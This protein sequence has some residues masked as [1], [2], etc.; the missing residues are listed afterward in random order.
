MLLIFIAGTFGLLNI[1][2]RIWPAIEFDWVSINVAW[3]GASARE[4]ED[5]LIVKVEDR[6]AG[7]AGVVSVTA[8]AYDGSAYFGLETTSTI[9]MNTLRDEIERVFGDVDD[10]PEEARTPRIERETEWARVMLLF[11]YGEEDQDPSILEDVAEEFRQD[12]LKTGQVSEI[13]VWG[14]P[15]EEIVVEIDPAVQERLGI[16]FDQLAA[17]IHAANLD[18]SAGS[19]LTTR[20]QIQIRTYNK[21]TDPAEIATIPV[22]TG[23]DGRIITLG[24]IA[25]VRRARAENALYT[26]AN[27]RNAIGIQIMYNDLEDVVSLGKLADEKIAEYE[28]R[29]EGRIHFQPYIRDVDE[30]NE[31]LGTLSGSGAMG[32]VLVLLILGLLLNIRLS[33]WVAMGIPISFFGLLF[34]EWILGITINEMTLFGMIIVIGILVDDGIVIGENIYRHWKVL[35]KGRVEAA[36]DGTMEVIVPVCVS[37]ATT[38]VAFAPYFFIYGDMG[39]YVAQIG[40]VVIISLAFSLVE[41]LILLPAHLAHSKALTEREGDPPPMRAW[42]ERFQDRI[43]SGFYRP[44]LE[45][46]LNNRSIVIALLVTPIIVIAGAFIGNHIRAEFFPEVESQYVYVEATFP[47]GTPASEM[48]GVRRRLEEQSLAFGRAWARPERGYDNGIVDYLSWQDGDSLIIYLLLIPNT[49]RD[50]SVKDFG[51]ELNRAVTGFPELESLVIGEDGIFGGD[52]ISIRFLGRD[53]QQLRRA[54]D[55]FKERLHA[56]DGVKDIRDDLPLGT[57]EYV[58]SLNDRG[59]ALGLTEGDLSNQVAAAFEGLEVMNLQEGARTVPLML[60]YPAEERGSLRRLE[61]TPVL[62]P[63]GVFVPLSEVADFSLQRSLKRIR[64]QDGYRSIRVSAGLD[65]SRNDLNVVNRLINEEILPEILAQVDGVTLSQ[66]GQAQEVDRMVRS[67]VFSLVTALLFMFTIL[68]FQMKSYGQALAVLGLI[69]LGAIG[70][71]IGHAI[72]G[73]PFSFISFLGCIALAGIIVNDSVVL[74]DGYN[75]NLSAMPAEPRKAVIETATQRFRPIIMTTVTTAGG[76]APLILQKG[77]GGQLLVPIAVSIAFGLLFGT[78]LTLMVLP[79]FLSIMTDVR[80]WFADRAAR[81][82]SVAGDT[83]KAVKIRASG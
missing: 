80:L 79:T 72:L 58:F 78:F 73:I 19:V 64:H 23:T 66:S 2:K 70:A 11:I 74:I 61:R 59:R 18:T 17:V 12:L 65:T 26:R 83:D 52:P 27:G 3:P 6:L 82:S 16:S 46:S 40:L 39:K 34:L 76:M 43:I 63:R 22:R 50:F 10:Y 38:I 45:R 69:P 25:S 5:G 32:L 8:I 24:E 20:E 57:R 75:R 68:V 60:R 62:T 31:R 13:R 81:R 15:Q 14:F 35:G 7:L 51:R 36:L 21:E 55:L 9:D 29:Y 49:E 47:S 71:T 41:A 42:I 44:L 54:A 56:I 33:F 77:E 4:V 30:L 48:E 67:M 53:A 28:E 37:I 1:N